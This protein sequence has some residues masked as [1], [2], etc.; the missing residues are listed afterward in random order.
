MPASRA[1]SASS[2]ARAGSGEAP[3]GNPLAADK[4]STGREAARKWASEN[5]YA[6]ECLVELPVQW[7]EQ[8]ANAHV[9][10]AVY[11]R[12]LETGR[13]NFMRY[14]GSQ[15]PDPQAEKDLAG[16]GKGKGVILARITFDYRRPVMQPDNVLIAHKPLEVTERKLVLHGSVYSYAQQ[17]VV[18]ESDCLMVSYDYN[19]GKSCEWHPDLIKL[20]GEKGADVKQKKGGAAKL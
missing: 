8:D 5:G 17:A 12:W 15:L 19:A 13:L 20:L 10:N 4:Y 3:V 9:N 7:G 18:G 2:A 6:D 16:S 1:L 14:L 11:F